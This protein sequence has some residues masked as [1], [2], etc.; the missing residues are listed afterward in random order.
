MKSR[1]LLFVAMLLLAGKAY[2]QY[3][4]TTTWPYLYQDFTAGELQPLN[5]A[6]RQGMFNIHIPHGCLHFIDGEMIREL[7]AAEVF[8]AKIGNDFYLCAGGRLMRV[9]AQSGNVYV[10]E[11]SDVDM[12]QLNSTGGAYGSSSTTL[13]TTALSSFENTAS[14]AAATNHMQ[15]K[16]SKEDGKILPIVSKKYILFPGRLVYAAKKDVMEIDGLEQ[17]MTAAFLKEQKIKWKEDASLLKLGV[18][19]ND[20]LNGK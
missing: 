7:S 12:N 16:S 11:N 18:F 1:I 14:G 4:P 17:S 3:E 8:S 5:S 13:A 15:L 6:A 10:L 9:L 20:K 2:A 19:L